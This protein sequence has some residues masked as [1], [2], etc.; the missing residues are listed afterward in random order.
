[1]LIIVGVIA[2]L[3]IAIGGSAFVVIFGDL[4]VCAVIIALIIKALFRKKNK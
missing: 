1:M 2:V 4:I 3:T